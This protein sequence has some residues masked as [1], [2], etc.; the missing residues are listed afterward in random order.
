MTCFIGRKAPTGRKQFHLSKPNRCLISGIPDFTLNLNFLSV[1]L[2]LPKA[3]QD[4]DERIK[5][6]GIHNIRQ[7]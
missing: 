6:G 5:V 1:Y 2:R 3:E 7:T 4:E